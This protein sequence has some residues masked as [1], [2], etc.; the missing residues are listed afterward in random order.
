MGESE[1]WRKKDK[2]RSRNVQKKLW[3]TEEE[4]SLI[5]WK[6]ETVGATSFTNF[7]IQSMVMSKVVVYDFKEIGNLNRQIAAI[8][9]N[10][11]QIAARCNSNRTTTFYDVVALK[12]NFTRLTNECLIPLIDLIDAMREKLG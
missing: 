4:A 10:I 5:Q 12:E 8:G 6:M 11:N 9:N 3:L 7:A 2:Q 1:K